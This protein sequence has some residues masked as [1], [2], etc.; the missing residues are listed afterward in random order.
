MAK[1]N[2]QAKRQ[3]NK[4]TQARHIVRT[5]NF[6]AV[7]Q[8]GRKFE[9]Y[10][11]EMLAFQQADP[12]YYATMCEKLQKQKRVRRNVLEKTRKLKKEDM[13]YF[14]EYEPHDEAELCTWQVWGQKDE[15]EKIIEHK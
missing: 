15:K 13:E 14:N 8:E 11:R 10:K 12:L 3:Q 6:L 7:I 1:K 9:V 5:D 4:E 2:R